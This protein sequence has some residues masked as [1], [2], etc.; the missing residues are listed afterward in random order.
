[1]YFAD[2]SVVVAESRILSILIQFFICYVDENNDEHPY[3]ECTHI[4]R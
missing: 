4:N 3:T 1:M 2:E